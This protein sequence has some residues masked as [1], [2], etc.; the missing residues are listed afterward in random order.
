MSEKL[1]PKERA[2]R[3]AQA[4]FSTDNASKWFGMTIMEVDEGLAVLALTIEQQ[5]TNGHGIGHGGITYALADSAF[6]FACNSRNQTTV[7]QHNTISYIAPARLGDV[8][9]AYAQE[10]SLS[11]KNG[12]YD[13]SVK[14]QHGELIAQF[15][16]CS[17]AIRGQLFNEI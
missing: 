10:V 16:G 17:R 1:T 7:A 9:T 4:M 3:S 2:Q 14:N 6:A 15:R 12:I 13:V 11:G 8:L 5:H